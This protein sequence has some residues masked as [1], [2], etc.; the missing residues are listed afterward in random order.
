MGL[1]I[2]ATRSGYRYVMTMIDDYS[3]YSKTYLLSDKSDATKKMKEYLAEMKMQFNR[4]PKV[5]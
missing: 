4:E 1:V 2:R 5:M 3:G